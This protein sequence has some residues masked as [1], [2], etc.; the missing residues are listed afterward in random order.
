MMFSS[1]VPRNSGRLDDDAPAR[2]AL[3]DVVVSLAGQFQRDALGQEGAKALAGGTLK[4]DLDGVIR[5]A[6]MTIAAGDLIRKHGANGAIDVAHRRF[7]HDL[8][9][10][11]K[12]RLRLGDQLMIKRPRKAV[13]L[14]SHW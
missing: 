14:P 1:G 10:L 3:A 12:R 9:P 5:Q 8:L 7:D 2:Q 11:F 13:I 6:G 4:L